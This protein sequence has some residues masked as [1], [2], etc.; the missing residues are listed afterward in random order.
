MKNIILRT[1]VIIITICTCL[2]G[3]ATFTESTPTDITALY[4]TNAS[5]EA[6]DIASLSAVN[7][8]ADGLRGYTLNTPTGWTVS[9]ADVTKLLVTS[10]CFTDNNFGLVTSIS[11][12]SKAYYLRMGWSTG[13][14]ILQQTIKD[15]PAGNYMLTAD[16]RAAYANS[17]SSSY[18][19][20]AGNNKSTGAFTQGSNGCMPSLDW[21]TAKCTFEKQEKGDV[22]IGISVDWLSGGSCIL[23]DNVKLYQL[24][25]EFIEPQDPTE[26]EVKSGTEGVITNEFVSEAD[27]KDHLLQM[28]AN[29]TTYM[30]NDFQNCSAPN[31]LNEVCG[32]FKGENTMGSDEKG[33][34]PNADLSMICAFLVKYGKGKV[35]LP[36]GI[37]WDDVESLA[38]K[39]LVFSYSTHK[40]N[41]LKTCSDGR[42]W[43]SVSTSD[44]SWESSLWAM[45][46]AYSAF[47]QW[48]KLT[49][50]QKG[51]IKAMMKA[52]CNYELTRNIP[53][54]YNGDTKAEENGWEADIL[55]A[56]LGLFPDDALAER[57]FN[58]L[59]EFAINSYSHADDKTDRTVI[60]PE[61]DGK[62]VADLYKGQ[63]LYSDYT[64]QNHNYFHTSYQNVVIQELG[65]AALALKMFQLGI[66]GKEQWK[67]NAL[68][69]NNDKVMKEVLDWLAL[70]D[71]ELA[72]PN[73]NDWS[74]FLYDQITSY[75]TNACFLKDP[76]ALMLENLAYKYIQARQQTT[77]DGSWLLRADVGARR[78]G[79]E[80]HRVMMTWLMHE[81]MSTSDVTPTKW[82]DFNKKYEAAKVFTT[83]NVVRAST[84]DRFTTFSWSTGLNSYTGYIAANSPDKNKIIVPFRANNTG[85][86]LGWYTVSGKKTNATPV[87][88]GIYQLRGNSYTMNGELNTNDAALNNRFA[89]YST[90]G[91][92]VI[93]LD[94]VRANS[95]ATVTEEKGG[96]MAISVDELTKTKRTVYYGDT[97]KQLDGS[98]WTTFDGDWANIDNAV[99]FVGKNN[100]KFGFGDKANNNSVNTAK[101]YP[102]YAYGNRNFS[103]GDIVDRRNMVYYSNITAEKTQQMCQQLQVLTD[104]VP[105]GWNGVIAADPDGTQFLFLS[106]FV[107][108]VPCKL[109]DIACEQGAPVF[110]EPTTI[111]NSKSS[112]TFLAEQN[113]AVG[114]T[115][116]FFL[117]GDGIKAVQAKNDS[118]VVFITTE[119]ETSVIVKAVD[120]QSV[121]TQAV[122]IP[123]NKTVRIS[124]ANGQLSIDSNASFPEDK[125][126][127]LTQGYRTITED[128]L[129]NPNF[130]LDETYG[131]LGSNITS[132]GI[133]YENCYVNSISAVNAKWPNILPVNGWQPENRLSSGSNYC[134]MYSMPYSSS[135]FC[136]SPSNVGNYAAQTTGMI[137]DETKGNRVLTVLNSWDSG[138]NAVTQTVSL[139]AGSYR[140]LLDMKY[141]CP[142]QTGNNGRVV[143]TSGGNVNSSLTGI[144]YGKVTD[145]RYPSVPSTW[146]TICYD[147]TLTKTTEVTFSIG[148]ESSQGQGAANNTLLYIDNVR[149]LK[150]SY[151]RA[152]QGSGWGTICL[153]N[154]ALPVEGVTAYTVAGRSDD[155]RKLFLEEQ[156]AKMEAGIPYVFFST[157]KA[158]TF[159]LL[160]NEEAEAP[161]E[162]ANQLL[163]TFLPTSKQLADGEF[164]LYKDE[165]YKCTAEQS[166]SVEANQAYLKEYESIPVIASAD[167]EMS[168]HDDGTGIVLVNDN[169]DGISGNG[170]SYTINGSKAA[171]DA[172]G[173]I[174]SKGRKEIR[175]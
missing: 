129:V 39:S 133:T 97:H 131:S 57:W 52:E 67:T 62:T 146:E 114:N 11:E 157:S 134:R 126:D 13:T 54:G 93:Y 121:L 151:E 35:S 159:D 75:S 163:G 127:N 49:D 77:S 14:T 37:T 139:P 73:G 42:Y 175:K 91:N 87:V 162:G 34:R 64:L 166:F 120:S 109:S 45:S 18:T 173:I 158:A 136:V 90:P 20:F 111:N 60:D 9:G 4:I 71:G 38:M 3:Y 154:A 7:N 23:I 63:N 81:F 135:L 47:F 125:N 61:Y 119:K 117:T 168:I 118:S 33:V 31:S 21:T 88:S 143:T 172:R 41:K 105:N 147:F 155:Y 164:V 161:K 25:D 65:E 149:L 30:K 70:A 156:A 140:I 113:H 51:Y 17:A 174:I 108:D 100:K 145:Y 28:L 1:A 40:A 5:F 130:E 44:Y 56:T 19:L 53:T 95:S 92:A 78:M 12:G 165:W 153:P 123:A 124:L 26:S 24:D 86:I 101:I 46:V 29:F 66:H 27:M 104:K 8:S 102:M 99:G 110:S 148:Y 107:S 94:Y 68:M 22:N 58:R 43:G 137:S 15:L 170:A 76:D 82:D 103:A 160:L 10:N 84:P 48:D 98:A 36:T 112:A 150:A 72:M 85:N 122:T 80:A 106:N 55:A 167:R 83:Q 2:A 16:I 6:D 144:R 89:L 132:N 152:M 141:E 79:V 116:K 69:H 171:E 59:R 138:K 128:Y 96:L 74:L 50:R 32:C 142:N 115:L 169:A